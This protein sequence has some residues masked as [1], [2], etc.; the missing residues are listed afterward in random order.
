MK[1]LLS[2][3]NF[4]KGRFQNLQQQE[5]S[6]LYATNLDEINPPVKQVLWYGHNQCM[7]VDMEMAL[8]PF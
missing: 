2:G 4:D 6:F 5:L 7:D 3:Q 8:R 1:L